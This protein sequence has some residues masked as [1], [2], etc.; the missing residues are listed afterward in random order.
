MMRL[1]M[2]LTINVEEV[3]S[4][5]SELKK[6]PPATII[7]RMKMDELEI[8]QEKKNQTKYKIIGYIKDDGY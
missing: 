8:H 6:L 7:W 4:V 5:A 2:P 3:W 1:F